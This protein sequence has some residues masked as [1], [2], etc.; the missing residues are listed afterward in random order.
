M[1][2]L[3]QVGYS[4]GRSAAIDTLAECDAAGVAKLRSQGFQRVCI[5]GGTLGQL[6]EESLQMTFELQSVVAG[7][8]DAAVVCNSNTMISKVEADEIFSCLA[9]A[10][11]TSAA[12]FLTTGQDCSA[13]IPALEIASALVGCGAYRRVLVLVY[14][15]REGSDTRVSPDG[16]SVFSDGAV[17]CVVTDG[18]DGDELLGFQSTAINALE[19][20]HEFGEA[21]DALQLNVEACLAKAGVTMREVSAIY[22]TNLGALRTELLARWIDSPKAATRLP[23]QSCFGHVHSCDNL[24]NMALDDPRLSDR[25]QLYML[26]AWSHRVTGAVILRRSYNN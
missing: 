12:T 1:P 24:I 3:S 9:R 16:M 8:I 21:L 7:D 25:G 26:I 22:P 17:S 11:C 2:R 10:G 15:Y 5:S 18:S 23:S 13:T 6:C 14:G 20:G 4:V 19:G